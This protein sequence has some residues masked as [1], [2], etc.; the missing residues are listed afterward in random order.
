MF[1]ELLVEDDVFTGHEEGGRQEVVLVG[2]G[3]V[4]LLVKCPLELLQI[5]A[6]HIFAA[7]FGPPSEV[8]DLGGGLHAVLLEH[9]LYLLLFAPH[10][11]P[12]VCVG[13]APLASV[14]PLEDA[15]AEGS[16][17]LD[18]LSG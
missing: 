10:H 18:A 14:H 11:V 16:L 6:K 2:L 13:L 8:V 12:V 7:E 15:V 17:E 4:A 9:P 3:C 1:L 5:F